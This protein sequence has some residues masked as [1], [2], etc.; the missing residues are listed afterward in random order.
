MK[1]LIGFSFRAKILQLGAGTV[2]YRKKGGFLKKAFTMTTDGLKLDFLTAF[3]KDV[4]KKDRNWSKLLTAF[5]GFSSK[6]SALTIRYKTV[7]S[8]SCANKHLPLLDSSGFG[9]L[10]VFLCL[11]A[12]IYQCQNCFLQRNVEHSFGISF[13]EE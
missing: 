13:S 9:R 1:Y 12:L 11:F 2:L 8:Q 6:L 5:Q 7:A 4:T 3:L 10:K